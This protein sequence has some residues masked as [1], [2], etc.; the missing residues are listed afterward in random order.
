M[1][2]N[3]IRHM[4]VT[5]VVL[6]L[7]ALAGTLLV[8]TTNVMTEERI[9]ENEKAALLQTLNTLI[10]HDQYD[11]DL[12]SDYIQ[13]ISKEW[14]G[15]GKAVRIYR[16]RLA[17]R[18]VAAI[19]TAVAPDG[20]SGNIRLLVAVKSDGR[21][22]GVRVLQHRET[23]GLGDGIDIDRSPWIRQFDGRSLADPDELGWNVV[24]DGGVFDQFTGA[25]ISPRAVVKAVHHA[26]V[27]YQRH[28]DMIFS[29]PAMTEEKGRGNE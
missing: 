7:F 20:Y 12:T 29:M 1:S 9:R 17:G 23:P 28:E 4:T 8:S 25:T 11:N 10:P 21:L 18:P 22:Y 2:N 19:L 26:L 13:V 16:A 27:Y 15:S 6:G 3:L 14:L 5:A 24:K